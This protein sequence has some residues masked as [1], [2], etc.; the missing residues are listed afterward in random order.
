MSETRPLPIRVEDASDPAVAEF[1]DIRERDLVG[2]TGRFIAEGTVVLNM[3]AA[4]HGQEN[5]FR[6]EKILV[7][8]NRLA[9][10]EDMLGRFPA[11]VPVYTASAAVIDA[12]AGFHLHRGVLA[13][14][15]KPEPRPLNEALARLSERALV[16]VLSGISNHDNAGAIFRNSA[17]FGASLV[18]LDETS[19]DPLYRKAIRV[20]VGSVLTVPFHR[21]GSIDE[22]LGKLDQ[23]GFSIWGLSPTGKTPLRNLPASNRTALLLG[24]EGEGLPQDLM[25]RINTARIAQM[26]GLDSLNVATAAA[27]SLHEM[28][29][30][31]G[32]L[33]E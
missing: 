20:S 8:E 2:R 19:C 24:T 12:I 15:R 21:G 3:L 17:A 28:A 14:G 31:M 1:R 11:D 4:A 27:L 7:L 16:T 30:R 22:I 10:L 26:P 6:A 33:P 5:G 32:L 18:I 23:A 25:R 9:G 29:Y 13:L